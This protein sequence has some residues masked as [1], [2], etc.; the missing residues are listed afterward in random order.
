MSL[1]PGTS[2]SANFLLHIYTP[3]AKPAVSNSGE[4]E[5]SDA[6][7][8]LATPATLPPISRPYAND[9]TASQVDVYKRGRRYPQT[10]SSFVRSYIAPSVRRLDSLRVERSD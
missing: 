2:H 9:G 1:L 8:Q 7:P 3:A 6:S 5:T 4:I 10:R